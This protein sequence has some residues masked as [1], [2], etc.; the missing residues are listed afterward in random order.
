MRCTNYAHSHCG[1][2]LVLAAVL[3]ILL[4]SPVLA[5]GPSGSID[6]SYYKGEHVADTIPSMI[7]SGRS[8]PVT[9]TFRN[10]GMV[11]WEWGVE[12]FGLL[13]Q[14]L[15]SSIQ[16]D[17]EF[18]PLTPGTEIKS[19][20]EITFALTLI[21]PEKPG[22]YTMSFSMA[23]LKGK[24]YVTFPETFSKSVQV[25]SQSGISSGSV[26]S[27]IIESVPPGS[28]VFIGGDLRGT[29]PLTI[30]DL[31]PA[32]YEVTISVPE[33][34]T[35]AITVKVE[36]GS[37]SRISADM[38][39][40]GVPQVKTEKDE[41]YTLLGF[42]IANLPLLILTIAVLFFG[43]QMLMMDT[44]RFPENHPVRRFVR[45]ITFV[46]VN[47]EAKRASRSE[48]QGGHAGTGQAGDNAGAGSDKK[49]VS[50]T[51][52]SGQTGVK[53][54]KTTDKKVIYDAESNKRPITGDEKEEEETVADVDQQYQD[55]DNPF[56]FP[57]RLKDRYEPLGVAGDDP[58]ARIFKVR[59]KENGHI[60]ALKVS[61]ARNA[62]S[63]ILQK[64]VSVWGNLRHPNVVR[65]YKAEFDEDLT[66]L[67]IEYLDGIRYRGKELTSLATLPKP[68]KEKYAISLI[69]DIAAGLR[70]T[71]QL[72][73]RH[74]H[75]QVGD[76][77]LTPKM[78]AK[79]SGYARGKNELGFSVPES[80]TREATA[81]YLAPEQ[82][83][84]MRF[85]NPGRKTDLYQVGVIFYE[86][87]TGY[88]PY[89]LEA[90]TRARDIEWHEHGDNRLIPPSVFR[91]DLSRYDSIISRLLSIEKKGRYATVDEFLADLNLIT[92]PE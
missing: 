78:Q 50:S 80:D 45:P 52:T 85:G 53:T 17:P 19:G 13:Y 15:Q 60:R 42:L 37:V 55:R 39:E 68:V 5:V 63:E 18:S 8:Y 33:Y 54:S 48:T 36:A 57:D 83:D 91:S 23:T 89:S 21:P 25:I 61:H 73:I 3:Y 90:S 76:I 51:R 43:V 31:S 10:T 74:Y 38:A 40:A 32:T 58:Y 49:S 62:G 12:K 7:E 67:D 88:L 79:I 77:L 70:Y 24:E 72:G 28:E 92:P 1:L 69:R 22:D 30:P 46:P 65:L 71:H 14:G 82:K 56:G 27:I 9:F 75:L 41:R 2:F 86:L 66:F 26:G 84:E 64:E 20:E 81:A 47:F 87:L 16:V 44:T 29:T 59:R 6:V 11:S 35:K 34:K 4:S